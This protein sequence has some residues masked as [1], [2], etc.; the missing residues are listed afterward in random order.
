[1]ATKN[2]PGR[3]VDMLIGHVNLERIFSSL[4][5][6]KSVGEGAERMQINIS[7]LYSVA[8]HWFT[9]LEELAL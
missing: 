8:L 1:M 7:L 5:T 2:T 6:L 3:V 4:V 9:L